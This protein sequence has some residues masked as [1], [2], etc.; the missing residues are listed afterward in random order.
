MPKAIVD[1]AKSLGNSY[2]I[3]V[4]MRTNDSN[5]RTYSNPRKLVLK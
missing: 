1:V 3:Q 4:Q 2:L 5:T